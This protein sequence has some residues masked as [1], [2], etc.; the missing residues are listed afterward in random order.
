MDRDEA[1]A[2]GPAGA[3]AG[4]SADMLGGAVCCPSGEILPGGA[5]IFG[6]SRTARRSKGNFRNE[7]GTGYSPLDG[8]GF[9]NAEAC[10][11]LGA[12]EISG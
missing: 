7:I 8:Y 1:D 6:T 12:E 3:V 5:R 2:I 10:G 4:D 11:E 9:I